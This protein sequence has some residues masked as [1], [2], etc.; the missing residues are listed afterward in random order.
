MKGIQNS[1]DH[2][3]SR[4]AILVEH[5]NEITTLLKRPSETLVKGGGYSKICFVKDNFDIALV[6]LS[7]LPEEITYFWIRS[8]IYNY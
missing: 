5:K 7:G 2:P 3:R 8:I 4:L 6:F 1:P